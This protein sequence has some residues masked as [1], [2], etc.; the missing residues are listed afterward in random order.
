MAYGVS[1]RTNELGIRMALGATPL[2]VQW[3]VMKETAQILSI[4]VAVGM[5]AAMLLTRLTASLLYGVTS[6]DAVV[7][8]S[9]VLLLTIVATMAGHLPARRASRVDPTLALR[10]E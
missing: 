7:V 1:Q 9:S 6:T 5:A 3:L 8:A 2:D 10:H 4:G